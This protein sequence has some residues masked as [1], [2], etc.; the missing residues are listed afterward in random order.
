MVSAS[1]RKRM[2][3][4]RLGRIGKIDDGIQNR[5]I[6]WLCEPV[7]LFNTFAEQLH[8]SK[9]PANLKILDHHGN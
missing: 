8:I 3:A 2:L 5:R 7:D 6:A 9:H 1:S 4:N